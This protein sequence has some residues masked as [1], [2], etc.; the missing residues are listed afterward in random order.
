MLGAKKTIVIKTKKSLHLHGT[1]IPIGKRW[2][3]DKKVCRIVLEN[4]KC[5][6]EKKAGKLGKEHYDLRWVINL[7]WM[8]GKVLLKT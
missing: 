7:I 1:H 4:G 8:S 5:Y 6:G 3:I 2:T